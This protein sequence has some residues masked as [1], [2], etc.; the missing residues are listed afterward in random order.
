VP[1][2]AIIGAEQVHRLLSS[3]RQLLHGESAS[4]GSAAKR[5]SERQPVAATD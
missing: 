5:A 2:S 4:E 3:W 1:D